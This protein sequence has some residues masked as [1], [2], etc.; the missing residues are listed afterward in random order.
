MYEISE[1]CKTALDGLR[2]TTKVQGTLTL[3][4]GTVM[5]LENKDFSQGE[6]SVN[7]RCVSGSD[8]EYGSVYCAELITSIR[9]DL[10]RYLFYDG[11]ITVSVSI[12]LQDGTW[13]E[14]PM[15]V[16]NITEAERS[17]RKVEIKAYD[18]MLLMGDSSDISV[19]DITGT[20][21]EILSA[22]L[23]MTGV[24]L[25]QNQAE[26][27]SMP[28]GLH[29]F[30]I[31]ITAEDMTPRDI[32]GELCT[33][34]CAFA[35][36]D[37]K[38]KLE[39]RQYGTESVYTALGKK[40]ANTRISD[41]VVK[42]KGLKAQIGGQYTY[43]LSEDKEG[44]ILD[45]GKNQFLQLGLESTKEEILQNIQN[46]LTAVT[47]TPCST[48]LMTGHPAL[49]LGDMIEIEDQYGENVQTY[50]M[51]FDWKY[52]G[53]HTVKGVGSNPRMHVKGQT[54]KLLSDVAENMQTKDLVVKT[55][56][57]IKRLILNT[58]EKEIVSINFATVVDAAPVFI[59][60][61][62][63]EMNLDGNVTFY[64][65]LDSVLLDDAIVTQYLPRGEHCI[66][67]SL[68]LTVK[69]DTRHVLSLRA[70]TG[71]FESDVRK[72][73]AEIASL[74][75]H[76]QGKDSAYTE[77]II[78]NRVPD[79]IIKQYGIKASL[80]AQGLSGTEKWDGTITFEES[81]A[82]YMKLAPIAVHGFYES[83][84]VNIIDPGRSGFNETF[85]NFS[86]SP[87]KITG[88]GERCNT[89]LNDTPEG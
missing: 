54:E 45:I 83:V 86:L 26:I 32:L 1:A 10:D 2:V 80:L 30:G 61:V 15:G 24:V 81:F 52:R 35:C 25:A 6:L 19:T 69:K 36:F 65:Y 20:P 28:N 84:A 76:A 11:F 4:D 72:Q 47:Y 74:I 70:H 46:V 41:Y 44:L 3:S 59:A 56:T 51:S 17:G 27:D 14:I 40:K 13:E 55:G 60:T 9:T 58:A 38:G 7:S 37:R 78:D 66:T 22:I 49:D 71:Y 33:L 75:K 62:P 77:T 21:Y 57:N 5:G 87:I 79:A 31:S 50:I 82:E 12:L 53:R 73:A 68:N 18:N 63:V 43:S 34:L 29:T 16:Y 8:F 23:E 67:L 89:E 85:K 64:Y 48:E 39:I 88:F 42:Y